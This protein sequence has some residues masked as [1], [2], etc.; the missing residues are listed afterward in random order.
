M[1]I[2]TKIWV[3]LVNNMILCVKH[4]VAISRPGNYSWFC[5]WVTLVQISMSPCLSFPIHFK[6]KVASIMNHRCMTCLMRIILSAFLSLKLNTQISYTTQKDVEVSAVMFLLGNSSGVGQRAGSGVCCTRRAW[7][8]C[9]SLHCLCSVHG[10]REGAAGSAAGRYARCSAEVLLSLAMSSIWK[11]RLTFMLEG[12][13][14]T[15]FTS[16]QGALTAM[17]GCSC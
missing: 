2:S 10:T 14:S 9:G 17:A 4:S 12:A 6:E 1:M 3:L 5:H 13:W 11:Q 16:F 7:G 15:A 8:R